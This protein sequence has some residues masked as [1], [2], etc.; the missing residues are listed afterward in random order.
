MKSSQL[1][2]RELETKRKNLNERLMNSRTLADANNIERELWAIRAA[3]RLYK[4]A[5]ASERGSL[6]KAE[7]VAASESP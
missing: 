4:N 6:S 2:L 3:I 5:L 7:E 1:T